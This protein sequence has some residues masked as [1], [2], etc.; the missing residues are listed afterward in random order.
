[1]GREVDLLMKYPKTPRN[2]QERVESKSEEVRQIARK[3]DFDFFDGERK[4]GYGG[5]KY[6]PK[7]WSEVVVDISNFYKL[8]R[9]SRILDVG[10]AKGFMLYDFQNLSQGYE[11]YGI[12]ISEY[13][14]KNSH[15]ELQATLIPGNAKSLP[16]EDNFFDLVI[17]INTV[18][19]LEVSDCVKALNEISR[20]SKN[21]SFITVDAFRNEQERE[22]MYAWNLTAKTILSVSNWIEVFEEAHYEGDYYWFMP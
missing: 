10:C 18:H 15:P 14:I 7:Y 13:A 3:F 12:D 19:N 9:N 17:S 1:M 16:Y 11:L 2:L 22:R 5:F 8:P 20:V 4:Y 6:N 21:A